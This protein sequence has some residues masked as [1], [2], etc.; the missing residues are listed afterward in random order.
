MKVYKY[1][2]ITMI[3]LTKNTRDKL[4]KLKH[5]YNFKSINQLIEKMILEFEYQNCELYEKYNS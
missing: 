1:D 4:M 3:G 2:N 5:K